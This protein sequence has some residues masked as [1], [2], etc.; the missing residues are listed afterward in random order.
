MSPFAGYDI[1]TLYVPNWSGDYR[2]EQVGSDACK[3]TIEDPTK[4]DLEKLRPFLR[5]AVNLGWT[6]KHKRVRKQGLTT[7]E[8]SC[9]LRLALPHFVSPA[10]LEGASVAWALLA[11]KGGKVALS[12]FDPGEDQPTV[13][14][15]QPP[16]E[17]E[18][19]PVAKAAV[20]R[21]PKRGCPAP[22]PCNR[23]ASEVLRAFVT[24]K[25]YADYE[26]LGAFQ[27]FGSNGG[28]YIVLHR[29]EAA[30]RGLAHS[31]WDVRAGHDVCAWDD[32]VPPEEEMLSLA[33]AVEHR[34]AWLRG[35]HD[36]LLTQLAFLEGA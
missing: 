26:R 25:Q 11:V 5:Q 23:R 1:D 24:P 8:I 3:L 16:E 15:K 19:K 21:P 2:L 22:V 4:E 14:A 17:A 33:M 28:H 29:D 35:L 6:D 20:V 9:P 10:L 31:L 12:E 32:Q 18:P 30:R 34:E 27:S 36:P 13:V 7:I